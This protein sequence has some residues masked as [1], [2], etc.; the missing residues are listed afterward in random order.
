MDLLNRLYS[1]NPAKIWSLWMPLVLAFLFWITQGVYGFSP[2]DDGAMLAQAW[3]I[4]E[5]QIP[6]VDFDSIRPTGSALMHAPLTLLPWGMLALDRLVV[7]LELL[8]VYV[9]GIQIFGHRRRLT[10]L[11]CF[12]LLVIVFLVG[13]GTWP[14]MAWHTIDGLFVAITSLWLALR[15][16]WRVEWL[17]WSLVWLLAGFAPLTK[18]GFG[19][20]PVALIAVIIGAR[21][22][23]G[24]LWFPVGLIPGLLY[25]LLTRGAPGGAM[26]QITRTSSPGET[27]DPL[28]MLLAFIRGSDGILVVTLAGLAAVV[29]MSRIPGP[30]RRV[31][32]SSG[33]LIAAGLWPAVTARL[34]VYSD[35]PYATVVALIIVCA[36]LL[37]DRRQAGVVAAFLVLSYAV[38]VSR[39]VN[40]P[41][42]MA[43]LLFALALFILIE[44]AVRPLS[45]PAVPTS[46][47]RAFRGVRGTTTAILVALAI[48]VAGLSWLSRAAWVYAEP[49]RAELT[50]SASNPQFALIRMSQRTATYVD[51]VDRC[52]AEHPASRVAVLPDGPALYALFKLDNPFA[53]DWF[54]PGEIDYYRTGEGERVHRENVDRTIEE[55]NASNDWLVLVAP[56]FN[57]INTPE[58]ALREGEPGGYWPGDE[59]IVERLVGQPVTCGSLVGKYQPAQ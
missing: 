40:N 36:L 56:P 9:A 17:R 19:I 45:E 20:V 4:A 25:L 34:N 23:R 2:V 48:A 7:V 14:M 10:P 11:Q 57:F 44:T 31:L 5:L 54:A 6:H 41:G 37:R 35:W 16:P 59:T 52:I 55:L 43:G 47:A 26:G 1:G 21:R 32:V 8:W 3:R 30:R 53:N 28:W 50:A 15:Q 38:S 13:I 12:A 29:A 22:W 51:L 24:L 49:P 27:F 58:D 39:G 42:L 33:L 46:W 18:Q